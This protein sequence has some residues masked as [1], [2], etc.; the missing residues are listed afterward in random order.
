[1]SL[2]IG[3]LV[4]GSLPLTFRR[5]YPVSVVALTF[6]ALSSHELLGFPEAPILG[7]YFAIYSLGAYRDRRVSSV[8]A[9]VAIAAYL[10]AY[11]Y[12]VIHYGTPA[13]GIVRNFLFVFALWALGASIRT[14]RLHAEELEGRAARLE[15][16]REENARRA[17]AD[18][19]ARI[20]RELHDVVAHNVSVIVVQAGGA[21]RV[22]ESRP[23]QAAQA[24]GSIERIGRQA[25]AEMRRLLGVLQR[26]DDEPS[27]LKPQPGVAQLE[28]LV[29]QVSQ[30]GVPVELAVEG[31]PRVLPAGV[32]LSVYRIVQEA[33]TN[34]LKHGGPSARARVII[35]YREHDLEV[36]VVD[37][38]RGIAARPE[39]PDVIQ[40]Q[41]LVG[42]RERA[43]L[44]GGELRA[45]PRTGGGYSV[46]ARLPLEPELV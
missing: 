18:E 7:P 17:I 44:F 26:P 45:G 46:L 4:L 14:V 29:A 9:A 11:V 19:R 24:L 27:S 25:L 33:L 22:L 21:R 12:E 40:G 1:M 6:L 38:G 5:R 10:S 30:A 36:E 37:D 20:A 23:E 2:A 32:D 8:A 13:L 28:S 41:G 31:E 39:E 3:I 15:R 35:R 43:A 16:E 34:T 42:M